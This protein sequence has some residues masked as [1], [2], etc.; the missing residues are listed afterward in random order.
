M[1]FWKIVEMA[2]EGKP[3]TK[4][5]ENIENNG[6]GPL[7]KAR[8][9]R[10]TI[11][12]SLL[13]LLVYLSSAAVYRNFYQGKRALLSQDVGDAFV[14]LFGICLGE[15]LRSIV[16]YGEEKNH[17]VSRYSNSHWRALQACVP[18]S[19]KQICVF[20]IIFLV[21]S[22]CG[23]AV[24]WIFAEKV[25]F[26]AFHLLSITVFS[27]INQVVL[28]KAEVSH[29]N[30][31]ENKHVADGLAWSYY[32]GYLKIMLPGMKGMLALAQGDEYKID[33]EDIRDK[34]SSEKLHIVIPKNCY[35]YDSFKEVDKR[36]TFKCSMPPIK[37][38][39]GGVQE[40]VYKNTVWEVKL[41]DDEEPL[42]VLMEY[43]TPVLSMYDMKKEESAH[44]HGQDLEDQVKEFT[45]K[46][47]KILDED[48]ECK[49]KYEIVLCGDV[50]SQKLSEI[51]RRTIQKEKENKEKDKNI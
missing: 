16:L 47:Q 43:A 30:E 12:F 42:Y 29:L 32:F 2:E 5:L 51:M 39:R 15:L 20:K 35:T 6:F 44:F 21:I 31:T 46:L 7:P 18:Y 23:T 17:T 14:I 33:G 22:F 19:W 24:Y 9:M 50:K 13:V 40:R 41:E 34:L 10:D 4:R 25:S 11:L 3:Q 38:T 27:A 49:N 28:S 36:I 48:E 45:T 37:K 8:G 1:Y 26:N